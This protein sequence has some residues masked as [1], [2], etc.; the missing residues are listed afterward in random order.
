MLCG[1]EE[2][3]EL[4]GMPPG[5]RD[6]PRTIGIVDRETHRDERNTCGNKG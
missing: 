1:E 5:F 2:F 4:K 3:K 6:E